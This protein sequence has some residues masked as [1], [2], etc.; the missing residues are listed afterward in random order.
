M[1]NINKKWLLEELKEVQETMKESCAE[2][3]YYTFSF[4]TDGYPMMSKL[5]K[6]LEKE[7]KNERNE[8]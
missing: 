6:Q 1:R 3:C 5:M 2:R 4:K 8:R 7:I